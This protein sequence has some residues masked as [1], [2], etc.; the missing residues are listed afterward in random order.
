MKALQDVLAKITAYPAV[1]DDA[2]CS[3]CHRVFRGHKDYLKIL[4]DR[5]LENES[6]LATC[7]CEEHKAERE[8]ERR[9]ELARRFM[10]A[11]LPHSASGQQARL[12]TNFTPRAETQLAWD[13]AQKLASAGEA[14]FHILTLVGGVGA[15]KTHLLEAI[16]RA[17][18]ELNGWVKYCFVPDLLNALRP[19][20]AGKIE[21]YLKADFLLLDDVGAEKGTEWTTEQLML[22]VDKFY[23][24]GKPMAVS[25]ESSAD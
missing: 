18:I 20:G 8:R 25:N 24:E 4:S 9:L 2:L 16:G 19:G 22:V 15:G 12:F 17:V 6:H 23:R 14:D 5:G 7:Y 1:P 10:F 13:A 21:D 3:E 11:E